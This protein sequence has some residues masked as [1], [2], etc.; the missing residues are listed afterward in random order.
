MKRIVLLLSLTAQSLVSV[1]AGSKTATNP[2]SEC[3]AED[4]S[5]SCEKQ[6]EVADDCIKVNLDMGTTTPWTGSRRC[7]LKVFADS[8]S[9]LVFT[10]ESLYAVCGYT[11]KRIGN[12][13]LAD[14]TTPREVVFSHPNGEP[15]HFVFADGESLGRPDP[16]F[17]VKMD[18][19]LM[20]VDAQGWA[21]TNS[22]V[23]YDLYETDGTVRRYLA[24]D[25]TNERGRLVAVTDSRGVRVTSDDMGID[26]VYGP[27]GVRQFLT[28]SRL[29]DVAVR[30][31][32]YDI[33]IHPVSEPP[34]KDPTTGRYPVPSAPPVERLSIR[35]S[36]GDRRAVVTLVK[37]G[38]DPQTFVF[39]Y[40]RGDWSLTRP[41]GVGE[42]R[43]RSIQDSKCARTVKE[44]RS[45]TGELLSRD[46]YN[47]VWK[48]WG[49][50][51][52]NHVEG[53]GGVTR[54]TGWDYFTSGNGKGQVR[55]EVK[56]TGLRTEYAYDANDRKISMRR[57]G[58]DMMTETVTYSYTSVDPS[59]VVPPVDTR[60]RTVVRTLDGVECERTYYVYSPLTNVVER[61]GT[62]GAPYGGTNALR[63]VTAF[64][65]VVADDI[66]SGR[67]RSVRH[68]NGKVDLYD[69]ALVTN[70]WTEIVTH[71]HEQSPDPVSGKTTRDVALTNV[72][73]ER[74]EQRTE[75]FIDGA[76]HTIARER[77]TYNEQGKVVRSENL[78]GQ[79]TT[80][81]WD[82]CHK[83]METKPDGSTTTWDYDTEGRMVAASRLIPMTLTNVTWLTTCYRYD[84]LGRQVATWQTNYAAHIGI[85][86][87]TTSYDALGRVVTR[88]VPG[89]GTSRTS[90]SANGLVVTSTAPNGATT[91]TRRN[92]DGDTIS[93]TGDGVT[94]EFYSRG[95]LAD[96]TRWTKT[97]R[98]ESASSPRFTKSCENMLGETVRSEKSG[99]RGAVLSSVN[100]YDNYGRLVSSS[101]DGEPTT[102]QTYDTLGGR[103]A[104]TMRVASGEWRKSE[105]YSAYALRDSDVWAV[106][107]N[108]VSCSDTTI[109]AQAQTRASRVTGL[110][111]NLLAQ[112]FSTDARGNTSE[113]R[114]EYDGFTISSV[115]I[116]P[117]QTG[118]ATSFARLGV[119]VR[120]VSA[121]GVASRVRYDGLGRQVATVDGRGNETSVVYDNL[122]R[123]TCSVDADG[124]RTTYGYDNYGQLVAVSNPMG[125]TVTYAYDLRGHKTYEGGA[126]YP[127]SYA[128]DLFGNKVSM[129]TY[130]AE[131]AQEGD[132]TTWLY[133]EALSC[134]TNKVYADGKGPSYDYDTHGRLTK[135]TW[136]RG[137]ET[138]YTY[139][140]WGNLTRTDYSD[141]TPSVVLTYDAMGRQTR[142]VDAAGVTT[143]A[144]DSFGSLTN[145]T[146]VGVAGTNTIERF[147]DAFGRDAG[148][149]LNG[150]RQ[151]TLSYDQAT[152]RL[153]TMLVPE[154]QSNTQTNQTIKQFS[155]SYLLGS[156]LK[157]SLAYPNGLTASWTYGNRGELLE[158][159]NASPTGTISRYVYTYD[160]A[161]RR[162][163][164]DKSGSAFTTP[165]TY[166]YL[167]NVRSELTNAT[168][169]VDS[170][171]RYGYA[172]D[173]IGNRETSSERR[174]NATYAVNHL[175]QYTEISN[176]TVQ[177]STSNL[178][179]LYDADGNQTLVKTATGIWQ[180][181][182]NGENRPVRWENGDSVITM[183]YDRMCRRVTKNDQ[184]FFYDGY[185]QICNFH[186]TTTTSDYN[187]FIWDLSE[188]MAT[189]PLVWNRNVDLAYYVFDGNK[190]VSEIIASDGSLAAHYEY[191]PFGALTVSRGTS[192]AANPWRF[193]SEYV[194]DDTTTIYYNYRHYEPM[195]GRW[196]SL[197]LV[198]SKE[199][200]LFVGNSPVNKLDRIGLYGNPVSGGGKS[201]PNEPNNWGFDGS[202]YDECPDGAKIRYLGD[203]SLAFFRTDVDNFKE[204]ECNG[205]GAKGGQKFPDSYMGI[206]D[207]TGCCNDHDVCYGTCGRDKSICDKNLG[208]CM[209]GKCEQ[210]LKYVY[211]EKAL[212]NKMAAAYEIA[213]SSFG[214]SA[215]EAGQDSGCIWRPCCKKK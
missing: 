168:A 210:A 195:V 113:S 142:A 128:Y 51:A 24:T 176:S 7:S 171:Y 92:A 93:V 151:S 117:E 96:G 118:R 102:E 19:R 25:M 8:Q 196:M 29:A 135:R 16:G 194:E 206:V 91:I 110:S 78:A 143:F 63:A 99:F 1:F 76:W 35:S 45:R 34:A 83:I 103:I 109:P 140:A 146:V 125:E 27:D 26:I 80:T 105:S 149:A 203:G 71:I 191:A 179:P 121:S 164:C 77:R 68:E 18:E 156:D 205:C 158:V 98:G 20:M 119:A 87:T 97:V 32:G 104:T 13:L 28:P 126:T 21:C 79:V 116:V 114:T 208:D 106:Q 11:F 69:Y 31:D 186:S 9:P 131:N 62:Q 150:V 41:S 202:A 124:N 17:H 163:G 211:H 134:M 170:A 111:T 3:K 101:S 123:R 86:A 39:D 60:P 115:N 46:E 47:Y 144:Y 187:Y 40:V 141:S 166:A 154:A 175:N 107:T 37:G 174:T 53:F 130:R 112:T 197:D 207:F 137:V 178:Q 66:R 64:Y 65:P 181:A 183:S 94:P 192:S 23:Y 81:E 209:R 190:N 189:R 138:T 167:Y 173:D 213:V 169:A 59:D 212:C 120:S 148:Y 214:D 48:S 56:Q 5:C 44:V 70:V 89:H 200:V 49:F 57:S 147:Y 165:D 198:E 38:G 153:A 54:T 132:V 22:P 43:D 15:V 157:S 201:Y 185:L 95:V 155:W 84:S 58:P 73:G 88:T 55:T 184:R 133:D 2:P 129:T 215:F 14:R 159:N 145:E 12:R 152:G 10:P 161:G 72:R 180:I 177:P 75:A 188:K 85:P 193:S 122:G 100:T 74:I 162:V 67:I 127:V 182:Y 6:D 30:D 90:Y 82:C 139:D 136:A 4:A 50:A 61:V 199:A 36:D 108:V 33:A 52:T 172:F 42:L 160:A 204:K